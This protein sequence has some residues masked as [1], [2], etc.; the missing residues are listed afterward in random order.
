MANYIAGFQ[1]GTLEG[2]GSVRCNFFR[3]RISAMRGVLLAQ[4]D[5]TVNIASCQNILI[6]ESLLNSQPNC[7]QAYIF[8]LSF[9]CSP[10]IMYLA[11]VPPGL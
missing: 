1:F 9:G 4:F 5:P 8:P 6:I 10:I 11:L 7:G 2:P 3:T